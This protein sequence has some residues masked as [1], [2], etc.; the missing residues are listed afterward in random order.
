MRPHLHFEWSEGNPLA[1]LVRYILLG[2]G[3]T[4]P[5]A[6]E[7]LREAEKDLRRRPVIHVGG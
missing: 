1:H 2:R 7:I 4:A 5:V 3:D 6:R